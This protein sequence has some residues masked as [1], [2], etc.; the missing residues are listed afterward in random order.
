MILFSGAFKH[1]TIPPIKASKTAATFGVVFTSLG[2]WLA[3]KGEQKSINCNHFYCNN[4]KRSYEC[5]KYP[6]IKRP[7]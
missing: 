7:N 1:S 5:K 4:G 3:T 6:D 2:Y